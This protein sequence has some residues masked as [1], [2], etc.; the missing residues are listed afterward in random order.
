MVHKEVTASNSNSNSSSNSPRGSGVLEQTVVGSGAEEVGVVTCSSLS[1]SR[2]GVAEEEAVAM[3]VRISK[4]LPL[5]SSSYMVGPR[6]MPTQQR[7]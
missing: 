7:G 3:V 4:L 5:Y 2:N 1:N 6:L